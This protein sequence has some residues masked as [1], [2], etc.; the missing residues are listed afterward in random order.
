LRRNALPGVADER[1]GGLAELVVEALA[2]DVGAECDDGDEES[3]GG[4][5]QGGVDCDPGECA[6][7]DGGGGARGVGDGLEQDG[8]GGDDG[9]QNDAEGGPEALALEDAVP[10]EGAPGPVGGALLDEGEGGC[11][12]GV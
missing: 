10:L 1:A 2:P 11:E 4:R 5:D 12:R 7:E 3:D 6:G 8:E 9:R